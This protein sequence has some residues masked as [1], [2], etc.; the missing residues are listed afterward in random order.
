MGVQ[1][2]CWACSGGCLC[3]SLRTPPPVKC[4]VAAVSAIKSSHLFFP[5]LQNKRAQPVSHL[6]GTEALC[7]ARS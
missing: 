3:L 5:G 1:G 7:A 4:W 6:P 2:A